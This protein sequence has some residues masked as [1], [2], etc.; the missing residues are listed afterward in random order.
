MKYGVMKILS[1]EMNP[2]HIFFDPA[3]DKYNYDHRAQ[4]AVDRFGPLSAHH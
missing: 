2:R 1:D 3:T 4:Y